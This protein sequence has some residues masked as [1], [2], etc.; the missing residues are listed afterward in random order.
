MRKTKALS[1]TV[2]VLSSAF[3]LALL[4][5]FASASPFI[6]SEV[7]KQELQDELS[8]IIDEFYQEFSDAM[9][10]TVDNLIDPNKL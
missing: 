4:I 8:I 10:G 1:W 3:I 7:I 2:F 6:Q 9:K 5:P